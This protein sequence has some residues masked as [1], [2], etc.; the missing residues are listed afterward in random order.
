[1]SSKKKST[2]KSNPQEC[3]RRDI[4][5]HTQASERAYTKRNAH[6][7]R[8]ICPRVAPAIKVSGCRNPTLYAA[9]GSPSR[10]ALENTVIAR[11]KPPIE[12]LALPRRALGPAW[13]LVVIM[14]ERTI[15]VQRSPTR[16]YVTLSA[17]VDVT[18]Y[19]RLPLPRPPT[20]PLYFCSDCRSFLELSSVIQSMR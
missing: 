5:K 15:H 16:R 17:K 12:W 13:L 9:R 6:L 14:Y 20:L 10:E 11:T 1:M 19:A 4:E 18:H 3:G 2:A 8:G 7:P